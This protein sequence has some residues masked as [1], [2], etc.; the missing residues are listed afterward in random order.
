[1]K[2]S[3]S[4]VTF[5]FRSDA[6]YFNLTFALISR[7]VTI[8]QGYLFY[9]ARLFLFRKAIFSVLFRKAICSI[10]QGYLFYS[11][12][13]YVNVLFREAIYHVSVVRSPRL[14]LVF[15]SLYVWGDCKLPHI[16]IHP[17]HE[18]VLLFTSALSRWSHHLVLSWPGCTLSDRCLQ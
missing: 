16:C 14:R 17:A 15:H 4:E 3:T 2:I 11:A 18:P 7:H 10:P 6:M 9:S 12:R 13:L 1:M 5:L 8:P